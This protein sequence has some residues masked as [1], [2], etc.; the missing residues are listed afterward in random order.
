MEIR[1]IALNIMRNMQE[2]GQLLFYSYV[3]M[4][5]LYYVKKCDDK[6]HAFLLV[7]GGGH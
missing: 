2:C 5:R 6:L 1:K 3:L 4:G 7:Y